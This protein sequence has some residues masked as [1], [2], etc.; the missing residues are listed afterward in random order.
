MVS[1]RLFAI[2]ALCTRG[3]KIIVDLA[4]YDHADMAFAAT[5][6][7]AA[8]GT[9]MNTANNQG[10]TIDE[11]KAGINGVNAGFVISED[12]FSSY[13]ECQF[14]RANLGR[15]DLAFSYHEGGP[16]GAT[17]L[18]SE[19]VDAVQSNCGGS[20]V[21]ALTRSYGTGS[22]WRSNVQSIMGKPNLYGVAM[23]R[24]TH[25]ISDQ[26][27]AA[28]INDQLDAGKSPMLLMAFL[29]QSISGETPEQ[30]VTKLIDWLVET[31]ARMTDSKVHLVFARYDPPLVPVQGD[32]NSMYAAVQAA[33]AKRT[34]LLSNVTVV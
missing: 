18:S 24:N 17:V 16:E 25:D 23:E 1:F 14:W 6:S 3:F 29:D 31:G 5:G 22:P 28:F 13:N 21:V 10:V 4:S 2:S 19:E 11:W 12:L 20:S 15:L 8:D 7:L 30:S 33:K 9:W 27:Q 34:A 32:S 26:E